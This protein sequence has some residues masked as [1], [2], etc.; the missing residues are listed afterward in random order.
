VRSSHHAN[1][2][3]DDSLAAFTGCPID[4][5]VFMEMTV[6]ANPNYGPLTLVLV[7][8]WFA[9]KHGTRTNFAARTD[10]C[11]AQDMN[12]RAYAAAVAYHGTSFNYRLRPDFN[13]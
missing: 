9:S 2:I 5:Y 12:K 4:G 7:I 10:F 11:A 8:L 1:A 13:I 6:S 3:T